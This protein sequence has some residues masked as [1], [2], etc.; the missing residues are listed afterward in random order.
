MVQN[1]LH[2]GHLYCGSASSPLLSWRERRLREHMNKFRLIIIF[3]SVQ[4]IQWQINPSYAYLLG[5]Y[6][7][8][9][10]SHAAL[11]NFPFYLLSVWSAS[12]HRSSSCSLS[13]TWFSRAL[14]SS[15][16]KSSTHLTNV[17]Q[18]IAESLVI[19][20]LLFLFSLLTY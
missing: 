2:F 5:R 19:D 3:I 7:H 20:M 14:K 12:T 8:I 10:N 4:I 17:G 1:F 15:C 18:L 11:T 13:F 16:G 9:N 6:I